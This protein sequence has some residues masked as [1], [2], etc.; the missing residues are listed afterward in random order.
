MLA[1]MRTHGQRYA[2]ARRDN[3]IDKGGVIAPQTPEN[4]GREMTERRAVP[5]R[6]DGGEDA[7]L[8]RELGVA[9]GVDAPIDAVEHAPCDPFVDDAVAQAQ[10]VQLARAE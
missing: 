6:E 4:R 10:R 1:T 5:G 8:E 9:D 7:A 2:P 3:D